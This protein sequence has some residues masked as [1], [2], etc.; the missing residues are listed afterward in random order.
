MEFLR[1]MLT[2]FGIVL[3]ALLVYNFLG[4]ANRFKD[5]MRKSKRKDSGFLSSHIDF[6]KATEDSFDGK[7]KG[8][9]NE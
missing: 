2:V 7:K 8:V 9:D 4:A 1:Q 6:M 3:M 5:E